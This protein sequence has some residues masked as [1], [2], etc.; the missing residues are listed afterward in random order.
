M[1]CPETSFVKYSRELE[2]IGHRFGA[3]S[4]TGTRSETQGVAD[5]SQQVLMMVE[6][7]GPVVVFDLGTDH[8]SGDTA[9]ATA[10]LR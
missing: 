7:I 9:A 2:E 4:G 5:G 10:G 6:N 1:G 8:Q 3:C